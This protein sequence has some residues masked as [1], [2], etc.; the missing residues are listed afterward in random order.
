MKS[1]SINIHDKYQFDIQ[2]DYNLNQSSKK[3]VSDIEAY[4]FLPNSLGLNRHSYKRDDFSIF[5]TT[6]H[7][8]NDPK[9]IVRKD[10]KIKDN[11][12]TL[13]IE[14]NGIGLPEDIDISQ[15]NTLGLKLINI[16]VNQI[17]AELK[18]DI[19]NGTKFTLTFEDKKY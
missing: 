5:A 13:K 9:I 1:D 16:L 17:D 10:K 2:L 6:G 14:N 7:S 19:N 18:L 8:I 15:S 12:I 11:S 3:T 4:L